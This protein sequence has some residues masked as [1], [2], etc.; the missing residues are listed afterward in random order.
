MKYFLLCILC[1]HCLKGFCKNE[2]QYQVSVCAIFQ[3]EAPY[4]QEWIDYHL[5]IGVEH[6]WLYN[7]NSTDNFRQILSPYIKK[8]VVDLIEWPSEEKGSSHFFYNVQTIAYTDAIKKAKKSKWLAII[9]VDE[10]IVLLQENTLSEC[11]EKRYSSYAGVCVNWQNFGTSYIEK[12]DPQKK[13][14][15]QLVMKMKWDDPWNKHFKSIVQP[16]HVMECKNPHF[17]SYLPGY[18][19]IN[20]HYEKVGMDS[21]VYID[22][23]QINHYWTRDEWY[24]HNVK[25]PRYLKWNNGADAVVS[26]SKK[27]NFEFDFT[28]S[29]SHR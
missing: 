6:F 2:F 17:C 21:N 10:F 18:Y 1:L 15:E 24:L 28:L 5:G 13:S 27:M 7:N 20:T 16:L 22:I 19:H 23:M 11:L 25:I 12:L 8:K 29:D 26:Q 4:L 14:Y 9:D 3:D